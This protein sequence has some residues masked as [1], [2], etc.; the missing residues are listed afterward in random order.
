MT[1]I[2]FPRTERTLKNPVE[3]IAL[4]ALVRSAIALHE[5]TSEVS[6]SDRGQQKS[7][8]MQ[9]LRRASEANRL[10][11]ELYLAITYPERFAGCEHAKRESGE[12][13]F[14]LSG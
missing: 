14:G 1:V 6:R 5:A 3:D 11:T 7:E 8:L 10:A 12:V 4:M 2:Q 13:E 9:I